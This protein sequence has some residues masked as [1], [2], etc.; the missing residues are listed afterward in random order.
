MTPQRDRPEPRSV[1]VTGGA[2]GIGGAVVSAFAACGD[3][4]AILDRALP[5]FDIPPHALFLETDVGDETSVEDA[6]A[7]IH[8]RLGHVD[9]LVNCAGIDLSAGLVETTIAQ[10][11]NVL[12]VNSTGVFL[13]SRAAV[14]GM[15]ERGSGCIVSVSSAL[16]HL[17]WR[18]CTAYTASKGAVEAFTRA[19]A[20][21]LGRRG[22][23]VNAVAPGAIDTPIWAG[24]LTPQVR[25]RVSERIPLGV[26]GEPKDVAEAV[27]F[28]ASPAAKFV[29]GVVFPVCGGRTTTDY[30]PDL[31]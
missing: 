2:S 19:A 6:F 11:E 9:V 1:V 27:L 25:A 21:E 3:S 18:N 8:E 17:G 15:L 26:V 28:L 10:W 31:Q 23:R 30:L 22:I 12:R 24:T 5:S 13:C 7:R 20:A 16:A 14:R 4:V 29:T